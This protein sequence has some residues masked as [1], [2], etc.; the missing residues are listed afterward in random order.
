MSRA[1]VIAGVLLI[2]L[3]LVWLGGVPVLGIFA[4]AALIILGGTVD[5]HR[6][7]PRRPF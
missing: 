3:C 2:A 5:D 6:A 4:G 7:R 1:L